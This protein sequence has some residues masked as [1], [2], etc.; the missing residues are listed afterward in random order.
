MRLVPRGLLVRLAAILVFGPFGLFGPLGLHAAPAQPPGGAPEG[1]LEAAFE[2]AGERA[3]LWRS[4]IAATSGTQR[5][6]LEF[7]VAHM[8]AADLAG[9]EPAFVASDAARARDHLA[10]APWRATVSEELF[11]E[12]VLP[13]ANLDEAREDWREVLRGHA[14]PLVAEARTAGEAALALNARLFGALGVRYSTERRAANQAPSETIATGLASCSGLSILLVDACRS[15]GVPARVVGIGAWPHKNG[16]HTWVEVWDGS[17]WRFV[18][19]AEPD[20]AG[21]DRA[22]FTGDAAAAKLGH[23]RHAVMA[24]QW[25]ATGRTFQLPWAPQSTSVNAVDVSARYTGGAA[26]VPEGHVRLWVRVWQDGVRVATGVRLEPDGWNAPAS[27]APR[28]GTSRDE[29]RD[30]NDMLEFT[31][32]AGTPW[33]VVL[34]RD[35][36]A[37]RRAVAATD[38]FGDLQLDLPAPGAAG[39]AGAAAPPRTQDQAAGA[40]V[41]AGASDAEVEQ[42][43]GAAFAALATGA[44]PPAFAPAVDARLVEDPAGVRAAA[45]RAFLAAPHAELREAHVARRVATADRTSPYT[46]KA[47]GERPADGWPLVIA[48]HGGGGA[49][50]EVNDQQWQHMQIYYRDHPEAGGYLYLALRAPNDEWNGVYDDAIVPLLDRLVRQ[51]VVSEGVDPRRVYALGYSHGGYGAFVIGPKAPDRFAAVHSSAAAPTDGETRLENLANLRFTFMVGGRD[52]AY[53]RAERCQAAGSALAALR[54]AAAA[55]APEAHL[56]P[57]EFLF[58]PDNGHGGLPDRDILPRLLEQRRRSAPR[59]LVWRT[60]DDRIADH[61]WLHL[62]EP[63]D[64]ASLDADLGPGN[65]LALTVAGVPRVEL[66]LDERHVDPGAPLAVRVNGGEPVEHALRPSAAVLAATLWQRADPDRSATC[67]I[68]VDLAR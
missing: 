13:Y 4:A 2:R 28:V 11:R 67:R 25:S 43:F 30:L 59:H 65:T 55:R 44:A 49:P 8:P 26:D 40:R 38:L 21:F 5:A 63:R 41:F 24:A 29:S 27:A 66:W 47:V 32:P 9:L 19:A 58:V 10:A 23:P 37:S 1:E 53:G 60:T 15:V 34:E 18:G 61:A 12:A 56:Y 42:A 36:H 46:L 68:A 52:T 51:L 20:P 48:M 50:P 45:W 14:L 62:P 39:A 64:G 54:E 3:E 6:D 22:W 17:A 57:F 16:N 35:G 33:V 31:L 7:L